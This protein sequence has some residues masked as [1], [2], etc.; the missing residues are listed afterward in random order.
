MIKNIWIVLLAIVFSLSA[1]MHYSKVEPATKSMCSGKYSVDSQIVWSRATQGKVE[2]WTVDGPPLAAVHF[3]NGIGDGENL[4]PYFGKASRKAK[5]PKFRKNMMASEV[6]E[7]VVDSMMAP[8]PKSM[9]GP[10][11]IGTNVRGSNL[12]PFKFGNQRG[13]RFDLTFLSRKG[14]EYRGFA[15]GVVQDERLYLICYSGTR[16]YFYPKYKD[17]AEQIVASIQMP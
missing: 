9:V 17:T 7:F 13:F 4:F 12:R 15:V 3:F 16:K 1:C 14:L 6:Q 2:I 11:M 8:Y 5:L 10:N